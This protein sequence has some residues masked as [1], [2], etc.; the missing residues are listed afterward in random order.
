V[1][2]LAAF[3]GAFL[4]ARLVEKIT[5]RTVQLVVAGLLVVVALA[6]SAGLFG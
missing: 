2:T 1:A 5:Y 4:G 3:A 6:L